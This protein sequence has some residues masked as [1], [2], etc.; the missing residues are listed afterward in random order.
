MQL[1]LYYCCNSLNRD[2]V[3]FLELESPREVYLVGPFTQMLPERKSA[4]R[5]RRRRRRRLERK[6]RKKQIGDASRAAP[7]EIVE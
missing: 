6:R 1:L 7:L 2:V 3:G 4:P 5:R